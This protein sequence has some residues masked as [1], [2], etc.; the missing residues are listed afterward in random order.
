MHTRKSNATIR[1]TIVIT[2]HMNTGDTIE[3]LT[4]D[5]CGEISLP[6]MDVIE[7]A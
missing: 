6:E 5:A 1:Q 7:Q 4:L 3:S 2:E